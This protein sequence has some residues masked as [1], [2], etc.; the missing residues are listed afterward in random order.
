MWQSEKCRALNIATKSRIE[1]IKLVLNY[2]F[3]D[4]QIDGEACYIDVG[5]SYP[6]CAENFDAIYCIELL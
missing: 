2:A 1:E 5:F 6:G 4:E 3:L